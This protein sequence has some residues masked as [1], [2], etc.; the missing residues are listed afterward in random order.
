[1]CVCI[2]QCGKK[3]NQMEKR[4]KKSW[5]PI[6]LGLNLECERV[7]SGFGRPLKLR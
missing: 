2:D 5:K 4:N 7:P 6:L 3:K 1:M